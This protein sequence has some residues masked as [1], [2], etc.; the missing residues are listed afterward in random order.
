MDNLRRAFFVNAF[1]GFVV[2]RKAL[3]TKNID[4]MDEQKNISVIRSYLLSLLSKVEVYEGIER[5]G[6]QKKRIREDPS[7][8]KLFMAF[9]QASR[10]FKKNPINLDKGDLVETEQ[11]VSGSRP[12]TWNQ[13]QA[14]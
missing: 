11:I 12:D 8:Q 5:L 10:H 4:F 13:L 2:Y 3:F 1:L 6:E 7:G 9:S 14:A